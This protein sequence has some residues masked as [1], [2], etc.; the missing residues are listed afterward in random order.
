L[1]NPNRIPKEPPVCGEGG[2]GGYLEEEGSNKLEREGKRRNNTQQD[3][4]KIR[5][6][7]SPRQILN[8]QNTNKRSHRKEKRREKSSRRGG[9]LGLEQGKGEK[10]VWAFEWGREEDRPAKRRG[11]QDAS[12][13]KR[14]I[15]AL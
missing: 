2:I 10:V 14:A 6:T 15:N 12:G 7:L 13:K 5:K 3:T 4:R 1:V 11:L 8:A 9:T